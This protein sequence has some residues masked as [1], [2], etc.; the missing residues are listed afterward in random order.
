M[1]GTKRVYPIG[2][3]FFSINNKSQNKTLSAELLASLISQKDPNK[4]P[5]Y[6]DTSN[7][8]IGCKNEEIYKNILKFG[9]KRN[10]NSGLYLFIADKIDEYF[11]NKIN[12]D[13]TVILINE[14]A[15]MIANE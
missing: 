11:S 9:V 3:T 12:V 7:N 6:K 1:V 10:F 2:V 5:L 15:N 13:E 8:E 4:L 14:K